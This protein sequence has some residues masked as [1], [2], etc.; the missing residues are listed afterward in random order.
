MEFGLFEETTA[1]L[2][3]DKEW[4]IVFSYLRDW[5]RTSTNRMPKSDETAAGVAIAAGI[6]GALIGAYLV[7]HAP[8]PV[9]KR[10]VR[11]GVPQCK[12]CLSY[13]NWS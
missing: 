1:V 10:Q 13:L 6:I 5:W 12:Y 7:T 8:C 3:R 9:C 2:G 11:K 4:G